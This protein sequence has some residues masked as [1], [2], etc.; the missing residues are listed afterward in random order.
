VML[1][2]VIMVFTIISIRYI[3]GSQ[4]GTEEDLN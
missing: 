2:L 4:L 3:S 1:F